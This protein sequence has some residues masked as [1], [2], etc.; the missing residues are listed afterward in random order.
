MP[1]IYSHDIRLPV[2]GWLPHHFCV[3]PIGPHS[4]YGIYVLVTNTYAVSHSTRLPPERSIRSDT[5]RTE[6]LCAFENG[7]SGPLCNLLMNSTCP[8]R[9]SHSMKLVDAFLTLT[10]TVLRLGLNG[11][12]G[13]STVDVI[14]EEYGIEQ[15]VAHSTH[16]ICKFVDTSTKQIEC[17]QR[18]HYREADT[19]HAFFREASG[20][21]SN[22]MR[23]SA[24]LWTTMALGTPQCSNLSSV[25]SELDIC[26]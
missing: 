20:P 8:H 5:N 25:I 12:F 7:N 11:D 16:G 17:V 4:I 18:R 10:P 24:R 19:G 15:S 23:T 14:L 26:E 2:S 3:S 9:D 6:N 21:F 13:W 1:P 22:L